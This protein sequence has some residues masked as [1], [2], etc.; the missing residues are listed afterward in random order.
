MESRPFV[1]R[2]QLADRTLVLFLMSA[3]IVSSL[4][5]AAA[6]ALGP[7]IPDSMRGPLRVASVSYAPDQPQ[8]G[9]PITVTV[10]V[11]G[12][13]FAVTNVRLQYAAYFALIASGGGPMTPVGARTYAA[14]IPSFP[15][16]TQVWFVVG[17]SAQ[18]R[19]PVLSESFTVDVGTVLR[20]G[21]SGLRVGDVRH[22]PAQ[23]WFGEPITVEAVVTSR[24]GIADV[25]IAYMTFCRE[26]TIPIDPPMVP[27]AP[28]LY[29]FTIEP[30]GPC[31]RSPGAVLLYRVLASDV[32]GNTA[33]S[34]VIAIAM[35]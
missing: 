23:P 10:E 16:G 14:T 17:V 9:Q 26:Q 30:D 31:A 12:E 1:R 33:V 11:A 5:V 29:T 24:A 13:L 3:V 20:G 7:G 34:D 22:T 6:S 28:T 19:D 32:T 8:P 27:A 4:T 15:D 2:K 35:R 18:N 21:E 25:D